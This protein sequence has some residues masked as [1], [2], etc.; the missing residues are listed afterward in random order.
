VLPGNPNPI[1]LTRADAAAALTAA[2]DE[3]LQSQVHYHWRNASRMHDLESGL[4][5][6]AKGLLFTVIGCALTGIS[7]ELL[8]H[9]HPDLSGG[10][11][12]HV[13]AVVCGALA[14]ML[15]AFI[16]A[17]AGI[18][19][20][21][22]AKRLRLRSEAMYESLKLQQ[23]ALADELTRLQQRPAAQG[24]EVWAAAQRLRKVASL[25]LAETGDWRALYPLH[26]VKA[27]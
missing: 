23:Q 27:G 9:H 6:L 22:E 7:L 21:S 14:A 16:A 13:V 3:W 4:E 18:L 25:M 10:E 17:L 2:R 15:P 5:R 19:F 8:G 12:L 11:I 20:Q 24:G 26:E 1:H